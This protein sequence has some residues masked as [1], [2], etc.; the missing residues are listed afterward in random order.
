[1]KQQKLLAQLL[2]LSAV[3]CIWSN[4]SSGQT[5]RK[6]GTTAATF[7]TIPVSARAA[8]MGSAVTAVKPDVSALYWNP[9]GI[10]ELSD[11]MI[12]F[13]HAA[14]FADMSYNFAG[15]I[16]PMQEVGTWGLSV[17]LLKTPDMLVTTPSQQMGTGETFNASD[18][19]IGLSYGKKLT[20]NFA[21][22]G[23]AKYVYQKIYHSAATGMAFDL[24][25]L[26]H[27]PFYGFRIGASISNFGTKMK[28]DG[29]DLNVRIDVAP[30]Q[31]GNNQSVIGRLATDEFDMPLVMRLGVSGELID[32]RDYRL[33][34]GIEGVNP[35]DNAQS[36]NA[37]LECGV[38]GNMFI[39]RAGYNDLFLPDS[40]TGLT[41]G[42]GL[43]SIDLLGDFTV[44]TDFSY[45]KYEHLGGV[46]R[47]TI[48][49]TTH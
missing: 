34:F 36:I 37:G 26:Y 15:L 40:E 3:F 46:T 29:E 9:A 22:G 41:I 49:I 38:L 1:M 19:C 27:S 23:S 6:I 8:A 11:Y 30:G 13:D 16:I 43:N 21:I 39:L 33:T 32:T 17:T 25:T 18:L 42:A 45:Q 4:T 48:I 10:G 47:F 7:L 2:L 28:M 5:T 44:S 20:Q 24:G 12:S 31:E 35:N 14:W